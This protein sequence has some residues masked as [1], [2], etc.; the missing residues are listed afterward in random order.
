[1]QVGFRPRTSRSPSPATPS[2]RGGDG[3]SG[4]AARGAAVIASG[5]GASAGST[6]SAGSGLAVDLLKKQIDQLKQ[7]L[8]HEQQQLAVASGRGG[9]IGPGRLEDRTCASSH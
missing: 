9:L 8:A 6:G 4:S 1:M 2:E 3:E 7:A 5:R